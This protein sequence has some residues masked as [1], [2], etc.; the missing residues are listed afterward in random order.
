MRFVIGILSIVTVLSSNA[1]SQVV[2]AYSDSSDYFQPSE[3]DTSNSEQIH[4]NFDFG[5]FRNAN[6]GMTTGQ[7]ISSESSTYDE[8]A[9]DQSK[10]AGEVELR[11]ITHFAGHK[12]HLYYG[13]EGDTL[14]EGWYAF[15]LTDIEADGLLRV[16]DEIK[17]YVDNGYWPA[18]YDDM[19][20]NDE[21][22]KDD[23]DNWATAIVSGDAGRM[24]KWYTKESTLSLELFTKDKLT[25]LT[26]FYHDIRLDK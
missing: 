12:A 20:W 16:F 2:N 14:T 5:D 4:Y 11:Y 18:D 23:P 24:A 10:E 19:I 22:Y 6:W 17:R 1:V 9:D 15:D 13:F 3:S 25:F 8:G 7:V 26:L 21:T